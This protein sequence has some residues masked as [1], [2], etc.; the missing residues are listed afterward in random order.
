MAN[1]TYAP[2][3]REMVW[4]YSRANSF[5]MC[6]YKWYMKYICRKKGQQE[7]FFSGY[8]SFI[9]NILERFYKGELAQGQLLTTYLTEFHTSVKGKPPNMKIFQKYFE[10]GK[11]Y[12]QNFKPLPF[13]VVAIEENVE[14]EIDDLKFTGIA[15][16]IGELSEEDGGGLIVIDNKSRTLKPRSG[17]K[18]PTKTDIELDEYFRQLYLYAL[19]V[20]KK[21]G[22]PVRKL[23]FNCFRNE[24]PLIIEDFDSDKADEAVAWFKEQVA[25]I[26]DETGFSPDLDYFKCTNLC[27]MNGQC[28]FFRSAER[29]HWR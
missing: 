2:L 10:D 16:W 14:L 13:N 20:Q 12:F 22:K 18:K 11:R 25:Y 23:G 15:D 8:G 17:K 19:A 24:N 7:M 28:E 6:K 3:I 1:F 29:R 9:H 21:Y 27:E 26:A 4:S 5:G